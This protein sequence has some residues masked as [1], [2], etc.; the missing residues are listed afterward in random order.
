VSP[1][2]QHHPASIALAAELPANELKVVIDDTVDEAVLDRY[3]ARYRCEHY[4]VQPWM[5][6]RYEHH[7]AHTLALIYARPRWRLSL[8]IHKIVGI[9]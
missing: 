1:K 3:A 9:P 2:P 5:D 8:Q 7:L 6:A 4:F